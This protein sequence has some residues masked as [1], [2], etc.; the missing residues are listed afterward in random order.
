MKQSA[1]E[2]IAELKGIIGFLKQLERPGFKAYLEKNSRDFET[3]EGMG[4]G[5]FPLWE[6]LKEQLREE[7]PIGDSV[8]LSL[9]HDRILLNL[10]YLVDSTDKGLDREVILKIQENI[11][12]SLQ[13]I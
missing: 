2:R 8:V 3:L 13:L 6:G 12:Q 10:N 4:E 7:N 5:A 11:D 9:L 1:V